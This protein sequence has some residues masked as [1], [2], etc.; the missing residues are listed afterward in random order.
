M[1]RWLALAAALLCLATPVRGQEQALRGLEPPRVAAAE[2]PAALERTGLTRE[3]LAGAVRGE[4]EAAGLA[5]AAGD[6]ALVVRARATELRGAGLF[7]CAVDLALEEPVTTAR[8]VPVRAVTWRESAVLAQMSG[9]AADAVL[10]AAR[11]L[12]RAFVNAYRTENP[13][14]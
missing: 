7:A 12:T 3:A 9:R 10:A 6:A 11:D 8:G 2:V 13:R 5:P 1:E 14:E 4:L